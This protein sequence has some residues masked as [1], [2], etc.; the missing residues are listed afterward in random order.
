MNIPKFFQPLDENGSRQR[1]NTKFIEIIEGQPFDLSVSGTRGIIKVQD[2]LYKVE[3]APCMI[4]E[5]CRC[6]SKIIK[7]SEKELKA[8]TVKRKEYDAL[9]SKASRAI[10]DR[11]A[12]TIKNPH[13]QYSAYQTKDDIPIDNLDSVAIEGKVRFVHRDDYHW[14]NGSTYKSEIVE[15][16]TWLQVCALADAMIKETEDFHHVFLEDIEITETDSEGVKICRFG[17]GS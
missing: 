10:D 9:Y 1:L 11:L 2:Q 12:A 8:E 3:G 5:G 7:T 15:N 17:M 6:D 13:V 4:A 14:G 16:P